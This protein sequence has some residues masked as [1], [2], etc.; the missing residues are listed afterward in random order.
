MDPRR[1]LS[2]A[3]RRPSILIGSSEKAII[4]MP[5]AL[6]YRKH[7]Q[8]ATW[9]LL[10]LGAKLARFQ[11]PGPDSTGSLRDGIFRGSRSNPRSYAA[12]L[13]RKPLGNI[14]RNRTQ[15]RYAQWL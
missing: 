10:G 4:N 15:R 9:Y 2:V 8:V 3:A 12:R 1:G 11:C 14:R 5:I 13:R 7:L 6:S